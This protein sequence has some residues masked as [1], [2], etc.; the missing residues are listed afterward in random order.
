MV[1]GSLSV[2]MK[3]R[4]TL[5]PPTVA[6]SSFI[7]NNT[8]QCWN[9]NRPVV[10]HDGHVFDSFLDIVHLTSLQPILVPFSLCGTGPGSQKMGV[11]CMRMLAREGGAAMTSYFLIRMCA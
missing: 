3:P 4:P 2:F 6:S 11:R 5:V 9:V 1:Q 8:G 7:Q 10:R